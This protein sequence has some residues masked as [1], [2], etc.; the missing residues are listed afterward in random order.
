MP[1]LFASM[2][3]MASDHNVPVG[4]SA[5]SNRNP[6]LCQTATH[7][8]LSIVLQF[9]R[10]TFHTGLAVHHRLHATKAVGANTWTQTRQSQMSSLVQAG[11]SPSF[12]SE[13]LR[14]ATSV[15]S[16]RSN[17]NSLEA[18]HRPLQRAGCHGGD[19]RRRWPCPGHHGCE[20]D[21]A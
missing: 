17:E 21:W 13:M 14:K 4:P 15:T 10:K 5:L 3:G 2:Q 7:G 16:S 20:V 18:A 12:S 9:Q 19:S 8:E 1:G 11:P 6:R